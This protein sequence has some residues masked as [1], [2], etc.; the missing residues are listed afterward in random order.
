MSYN[1]VLLVSVGAA[2]VLMTVIRF[3]TVLA[4]GMYE[5]Y[6]GRLQKI[7]KNE[8][9]STYWARL[10]LM[11]TCGAAGILMISHGTALLHY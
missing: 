1:S 8:Q 2:M 10:I 3:R 6:Q 11:A 4:E 7:E 5:H 9:P